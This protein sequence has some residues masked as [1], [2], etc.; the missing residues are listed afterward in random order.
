[1]LVRDLI[2]IHNSEGNVA[3]RGGETRA[4]SQWFINNDRKFSLS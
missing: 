3:A 1:M 4:V 2:I